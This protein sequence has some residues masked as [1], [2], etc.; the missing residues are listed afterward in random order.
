MHFKPEKNLPT[1][2]SRPSQKRFVGDEVFDAPLRS[3]DDVFVSLQNREV[4][5]NPG[6]EDRNLVL[7][8]KPSPQSIGQ[9][10]QAPEIVSI[11]KTAKSKPGTEQSG[12][13][14]FQQKHFSRWAP[15]FIFVKPSST[16]DD[17]TTS[18]RDHAKKR[19]SRGKKRDKNPWCVNS[20]W[21]LWRFF[22]P[23]MTVLIALQSVYSLKL[24]EL[25]QKFQTPAGKTPFNWTAIIIMIVSFFISY[26]VLYGCKGKNYKIF[27][28]RLV[29]IGFVS[30][31]ITLVSFLLP[32]FL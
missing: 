7:P 10:I 13:T 29:A 14:D 25:F 26:L 31:M 27:I 8:L 11:E 9:S 20:L 30:A 15:W 12:P 18:A 19:I 23:A 16:S 24:A 6:Q 3:V 28:P 1:T 4:K 22:G 17:K 2:P 21:D 5:A 32:E